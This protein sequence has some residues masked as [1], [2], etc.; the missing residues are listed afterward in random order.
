[1]A[2]NTTLNFTSPT[3]AFAA[4]A[5]VTGLWF[6]AL[7]TIPE[8]QRSDLS[9]IGIR[10]AVHLI[11]LA[12]TWA[13]LS[14]TSLTASQR[15][16]TWLAI[17]IPLTVWHGAAWVIVAE[18]LLLPGAVS[19]PLLPLM[20]VVPT[21]IVIT[22]M[23]RS[24]RIGMLLDAMPANWLIGLQAYRVIGSVFFVNWLAGTTPGIFAL[25]AGTGDVITGLMALPT[26]V[27]LAGGR[28]GG[29]KAAL[30]WNL[31]GI[32][33]LVVAVTLG[34]LTTPGPL[35]QLALDHPNLTTGTYPT[36][37]IPAFTV[38]TSLV[39]HALSLRQ[40]LRRTRPVARVAV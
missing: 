15:M 33:D 5:A 27:A 12:G 37:I 39:L 16:A 14:R 23:L 31:F 11:V 3:F 10:I 24:D 30:F 9:V 6:A 40:L 36:A 17:A 34:A 18:G 32:A 38:P 25:P 26:A 4:S 29:T 7:I 22:L 19:I 2:S 21:A 28:P 13:G 35:Q 1:M 20:I 8:L